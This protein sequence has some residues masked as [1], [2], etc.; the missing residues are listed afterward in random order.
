MSS[1]GQVIN[2]ETTHAVTKLRCHGVEHCD[3]RP[4]D[5]LWNSEGGNVMLVDLERSEILKQVPALQAF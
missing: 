1:I 4:P 5:V 2:E 3:V